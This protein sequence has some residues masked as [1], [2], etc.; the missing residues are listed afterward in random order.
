MSTTNNSFANVYPQIADHLA[1][2]LPAGIWIDLDQSQLENE[3]TEYALPYDI[4]VVLIDFEDV[5]WEDLTEG[6]Q[7]G[8]AIIKI[9]VARQVLSDSYQ[10]SSQRGAALEKLQLLGQVH[11][12]L[13]RHAG[14]GYG[15][16]VR[17]YSRK[18]PSPLPAVWVYTMGYKCRLFDDE[19]HTP[20]TVA[21]D[22]DVEAQPVILG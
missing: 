17:T 13:H 20:A 21:T 3:P 2:Q 19:G 12:A 15:A 9:T 6:V 5:A 7:R 18:E 22:V 8:D 14:D 16:M 10:Y 4:G 11:K 1:E